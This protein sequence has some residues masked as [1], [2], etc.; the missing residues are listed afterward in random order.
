MV[1]HLLNIDEE[2]AAKVSEG[3]GLAELP[4][5]AKA[6][7]PTKQDLR[8]SDALSIVK[9]GPHSF[10]GR[11]LGLLL[12]DGAD[13]SLFDALSEAVE[14]ADALL[15]VVAP[16]VAGAVLSD[17]KLIPAKQKIDG[18]PSVLFDAVAVIV[19]D[20]GAALLAQDAPPR[21]FINDAFAHCKFI[22]YSP[23]AHALFE[24]TGLTE[25]LDEG[26]VPI[27]KT[28]DVKSFVELLTELR[29]WPRELNV[30]LDAKKK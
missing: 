23:E 30:D 14:S 20:E 6:S 5:P 28:K 18:G 7:K 22:G 21:D 24:R 11:K 17:G 3:L 25:H 1:S 4:A 2:L 10:A 9:R 26:C 8:P 13:A 29:F 16:K 27:A 12:S 19:S 15:E